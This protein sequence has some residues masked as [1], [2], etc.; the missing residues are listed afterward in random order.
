MT[1]AMRNKALFQCHVKCCAFR[2]NILHGGNL[3]EGEAA[4][5]RDQHG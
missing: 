4:S 2:G 1:I 5:L 3:S